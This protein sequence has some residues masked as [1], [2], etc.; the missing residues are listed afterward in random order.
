L[1][2]VPFRNLL[3]RIRIEKCLKPLLLRSLLQ[4]CK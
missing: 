2:K 3:T 4:N 1:K